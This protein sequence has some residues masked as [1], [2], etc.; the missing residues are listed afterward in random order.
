MTV[1]IRAACASAFVAGVALMITG[2]GRM[3]AQA[4]AAAPEQ[5]H[6]HHVHLNSTDPAAAAAYYPKAFAKTATQT[7]FN[8]LDAVKTG[9]VYILFSKV[10]TPPANELTGPQTSV[11]HFGWNTPNSREYNANFRKMGLTI[12]QMWNGSDAEAKLV[13]LSGDVP[14]AP[15]GFP[16]Q[17]QVLELRAK[18]AKVDP[19]VTP[20]GFG[21]LRGPDGV[22]IENAQ[23]GEE[24]FNHVHMFHE[25]PACATNWYV[26]HLGASRPQGRGGAAAAPPAA[27]AGGCETKWYAPPTFPSF[28]K[29]GFVREPRGGVLFDNISISMIPWPGG[30]L[31]PT[32]G[33]LYDHWAVSTTNLDATVARLKQENVKFI[34]EIHPWGTMRAAMIQGPDRISIEVVEAK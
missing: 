26:E 25:H 19:A 12:A 23:A 8:G 30:G 32:R 16:T 9:N 21:Y 24:R 33:T 5:L 10:A 6:F 20:G 27:P 1:I 31:A 22:M 15:S 17:E 29:G 3:Q 11:W 4:P 13:D 34:E 28:A 7:K 2:S 14:M 18:G